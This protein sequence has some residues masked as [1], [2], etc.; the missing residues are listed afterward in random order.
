M[1]GVLPKRKNR[2]FYVLRDR[3]FSFCSKLL[4]VSGRFL[5]GKN[6]STQP[7]VIS[8]IKYYC[9]YNSPICII[10]NTADFRNNISILYKKMLHFVVLCRIR[11]I[12]TA[13]MRIFRH[14]R[15]DFS[16]IKTVFSCSHKQKT[17]ALFRKNGKERSGMIT[18]LVL[19]KFLI[20]TG[21]ISFRR[22]R[23]DLS[24]RENG[25]RCPYRG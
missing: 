7:F 3:D 14:F 8:I 10:L 21:R 19:C 18:P 5:S 6:I 16:G 24:S 2:S 22:F 12:K 25:L 15:H 23:Q 9:N 11:E 1:R 20:L 13:L 4:F 17:I